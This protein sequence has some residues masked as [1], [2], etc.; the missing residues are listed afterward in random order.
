MSGFL[1]LPHHRGGVVGINPSVCGLFMTQHLLHSLFSSSFS[2]TLTRCS[3]IAIII[4]A[5]P[6][7]FLSSGVKCTQDETFSILVSVSLHLTLSFSIFLSLSLGILSQFQ[8]LHHVSKVCE[9]WWQWQSCWVQ[10]SCSHST[11]LCRKKPQGCGREQQG[12]QIWQGRMY[13][14]E[15]CFAHGTVHSVPYIPICSL[16]FGMKHLWEHVIHK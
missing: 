10:P 4:P 7:F 3:S 1:R 5:Y 12:V 16:L 14:F 15:M 8:S 2:L 13:G 11:L 9:G 6:I